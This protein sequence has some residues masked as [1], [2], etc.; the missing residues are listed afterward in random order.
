MHYRLKKH[1]G[2]SAARYLNHFR[3]QKA[4]DLLANTDALIKH[5]SWKVGFRDSN[6]FCRVFKKEVGMSPT[7]YRKSRNTQ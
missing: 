6:Y 4:C 2:M 5:L 7:E 3:I 1:H